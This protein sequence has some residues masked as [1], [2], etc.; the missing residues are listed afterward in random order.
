MLK[1]IHIVD[2]ISCHSEWNYNHCWDQGL[3]K[4]LPLVLVMHADVMDNK[5][6]SIDTNANC[7]QFVGDIDEVRVK[8]K[9]ETHWN[10]FQWFT[11]DTMFYKGN[12]VKDTKNA[13]H[14]Y[15][16]SQ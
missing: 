10:I 7:D 9:E 5:D 6:I 3:V 8:I 4:D 13:V 12:A 2:K 15:Q 11:K 14:Q 1:M 16:P